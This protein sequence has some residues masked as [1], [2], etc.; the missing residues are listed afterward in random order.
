MQEDANKIVT[1]LLN[2]LKE[3]DNVTLFITYQ[4]VPKSNDWFTLVN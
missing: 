1:I 3:E 4:G 2:K